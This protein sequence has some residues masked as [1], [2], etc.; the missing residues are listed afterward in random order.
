L[1]SSDL[2]VHLD[3]REGDQA[4]PNPK[5]IQDLLDE[6]NGVAA[7]DI[8]IAR[9]KIKRENGVTYV[10]SKQRIVSRGEP[11]LA[12]CAIHDKD[13]NF[14]VEWIK[15]F[16]GEERLPDFPRDHTTGVIELARRALAMDAKITAMEGNG[17]G[18]SD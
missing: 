9:A 6:T 2:Q 3:I 8:D 12:Q 15:M 1:L 10:D 13:G 14:P 18:K 7:T 5:L 16:F 11:V 4:V 17:K